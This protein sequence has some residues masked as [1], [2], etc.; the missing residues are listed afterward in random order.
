[1]GVRA[2]PG[3]QL[4]RGRLR[5]LCGLRALFSLPQVGTQ[6]REVCFTLKPRQPGLSTRV[7]SPPPS[8]C[9]VLS[10]FLVL[11]GGKWYLTVD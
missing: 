4:L 8:L 2:V 10:L 6:G 11:L 9:L 3:F 5:A 7:M 1:M